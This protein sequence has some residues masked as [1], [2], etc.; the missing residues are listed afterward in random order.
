MWVGDIYKACV[1]VREIE[2]VCER[3]RIGEIKRELRRKWNYSERIDLELELYSLDLD[4]E[5]GR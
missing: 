1:W 3:F 5:R 2:S 4:R